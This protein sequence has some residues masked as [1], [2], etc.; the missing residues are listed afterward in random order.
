MKPSE[1]KDA[2]AARA[3]AGDAL[4]HLERALEIL[5]ALGIDRSIGAKLQ[6]SIET[7][8]SACPEL[9]SGPAPAER[10]P[11]YAVLQP[12]RWV[13]LWHELRSRTLY[14]DA[15]LPS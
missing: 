6:D 4:Q 9:R 12:L 15:T 1:I 13:S 7:L 14:G 3:G 11:F 10:P 8:K 2:D 5:D